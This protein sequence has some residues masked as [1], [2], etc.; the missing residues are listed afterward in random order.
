[1]II[2][3]PVDPRE[4]SAVV[5]DMD[6]TLVASKRYWSRQ[7]AILLTRELMR[8]PWSVPRTVQAL[9]GFRKARESTRGHG[10]F[11]CLR[12]EVLERA[13]KRTGLT[14]E[15]IRDAVYP[16]I[17]DT[18]FPGL[19]R[20]L[21]PGIH[22]MVE[23]LHREGLKVGILSDYPVE[24]K[25]KSA[26]LAG[27]PWD[28]AMDCEQVGSLKPY[29]AAFHEAAKRL[30]VEPS[31]VLYVGDREDTDVQGARD[32]GLKAVHVE[33]SSSR[34]ANSLAADLILFRTADLAEALGLV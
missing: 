7:V 9:R 28:L 30:G 1:M 10:P 25:L 13:V 14:R 17:Y 34:R 31:R 21:F 6:D 8:R 29:P 18:T 32:A 27:I 24:A 26:G 19:D 5:F 4:I 20:Y 23:R 3:K 12:T 15:R 33:H 11:G 22:E 2:Q 16:L